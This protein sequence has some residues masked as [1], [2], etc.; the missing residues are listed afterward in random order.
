MSAGAGLIFLVGRLVFG[1]YFTVVA[2]I[3]GHVRNSQMLEGYARSIGFP[4]A[5]ISGWPTGVWLVVGGLSVALGI[6]GDLGALMIAAFVIV[7]AINFHRFWEIEDET[8]KMTQ[9]QLF[10]RNTTMLGTTLILFG[11]FTGF[12]SELRFVMTQALFSL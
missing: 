10:G 7:A 1:L 2:G 6:L 12:G 3:Q 8:Q 5:A 9:Q 11:V 4:L